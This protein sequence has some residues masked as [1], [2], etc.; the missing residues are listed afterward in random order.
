VRLTPAGEAVCRRARRALGEVEAIAADAEEAER[1][2]SVRVRVGVSQTAAAEIMPL[3]LRSFRDEYPGVEVVLSAVDDSAGADGLRKGRFDL[4]FINNPEPD[5]VIE[6]VPMLEDPWVILTRRDNAIAEL[7]RPGFD[8]LDGA[9]LVA[10]THRWQGQRELEQAWARRGIAPK[11]VY[12]TDDNL[13]LQRLVAAGLG[14]AC[15]GQLAARRAVDPS[16]TWLLPRDLLS[17]R[18]IA[19]CYP[20]Q[21][22]MTAT[23]RALVAAIR[24]QTV[25]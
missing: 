15:I 11:I 18:E 22:Q 17:H 13:A 10:W 1:G 8:V 7:H 14:H 25:L 24:R 9:D 21:R 3:A 20:R 5:D 23:A 19:L 6:A 12:R 2:E 16:L 4:A